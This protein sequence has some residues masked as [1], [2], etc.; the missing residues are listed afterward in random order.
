[1]QG[2]CDLSQFGTTG[3]EPGL[4]LRRRAFGGHALL[5]GLALL[6]QGLFLRVPAPD[7]RHALPQFGD[8]LAG[9]GTPEQPAQVG[10]RAGMHGVCLDPGGEF[11]EQ[12]LGVRRAALNQDKRR[13]P[14]FGEQGFRKNQITTTLRVSLARDDLRCEW[15]LY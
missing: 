8:E 9:Q 10:D 6:T 4:M 3:G 2:V 1:M 15:L 5:L 12:G 11:V 7:N 13:L 14:F